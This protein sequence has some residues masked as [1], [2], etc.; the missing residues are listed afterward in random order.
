MKVHHVAI[1]TPDPEALARFYEDVLG[2][3]RERVWPGQDGVRSVWL[4]LGEGR[5]MLERCEGTLIP[6]AF[7]SKAPGFH[8]LALAIDPSE[9]ASWQQKLGA[10][11]VHATEFTLYVQDPD[12]N[13]I[14]L[15]HYE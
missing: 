9:R 6:S 3:Q 2:L 15:S 14:G 1:T 4:R 12:G 11:V 10:R 13:R 7:G 8:L 5:L